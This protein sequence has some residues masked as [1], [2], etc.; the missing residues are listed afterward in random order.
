MYLYGSFFQPSLSNFFILFF[1]HDRFNE[2]N[3]KGQY[4]VTFGKLYDATEQIFEAL[5]GTLKVSNGVSSLDMY[6]LLSIWLLFVIPWV[7][8]SIYYFIFL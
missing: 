2:K 1:L 7:D 5:A 3:D 6:L 4:T 8:C